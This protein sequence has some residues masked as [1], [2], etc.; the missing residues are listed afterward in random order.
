M[1]STELKTKYLQTT[2]KMFLMVGIYFYI[3]QKNPPQQK[4]LTRDYVNIKWGKIDSSDQKKW[5]ITKKHSLLFNFI[6]IAE[7]H[8]NSCLNALYVVR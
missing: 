5:K 4:R 1:L 7:N 2:S 8:N 6:Y 3:Y